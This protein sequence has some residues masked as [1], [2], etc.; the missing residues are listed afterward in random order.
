MSL[1]Y[2][3]TFNNHQVEPVYCWINKQVKFFFSQER[4]CWL[5]FNLYRSLVVIC[6]GENISPQT[7]QF[8]LPPLIISFE[9]FPLLIT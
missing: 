8:L 7:N 2:V 3:V 9:L 4:L 6:C 1:I 5:L